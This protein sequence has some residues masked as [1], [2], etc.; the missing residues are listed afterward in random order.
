MPDSPGHR[1]LF[2]LEITLKMVKL[3]YVNVESEVKVGTIS[4]N[5]FFEFFVQMKDICEFCVIDLV[6]K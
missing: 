2:P 6:L 3:F 4:L 1:Q 5:F